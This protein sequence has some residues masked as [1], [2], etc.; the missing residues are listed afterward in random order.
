LFKRIE[1]YGL[2]AEKE[3]V[4]FV[5]VSSGGLGITLYKEGL[6]KYQQNIHI[7]TLRIKE[8]FDKQQR[9]S[10]YFQQALNEY[11]Y[12]VIEP[13]ESELKLHKIKYLVLSGT[14]TR[15][16]LSILGRQQSKSLSFVSLA[17]FY[18]L[19]E[20]VIKLNVPQI[21]KA[22]SLPEHTAEMVLPTVSL[23]KQI[24]ALTD[25]EQI[26]LP[27]DQFIDG[28]TTVHIAEKTKDKW[29]EKIELQIISLARMIGNKYQYDPKHATN[30]EKWSMALFDRLGKI[31]GMG[32][33][34]RLL[35]KVAAI[36]HD[37]GKFVSLR[38][39]YFY[40]YRLIVSS[41]ILGFSET[42]KALMANVAHYHSK[43]IPSDL[44]HNF[45]PLAKRQKV[46]VA[47]LA[48]IIRLADAI[49]RTHRQKVTECTIALKGD[50]LTITVSAK[51]DISLEEW[52]FLDKAP[53]FEDV[54]GIKP[55]LKR[56]A[57]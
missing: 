31:H 12:S 36:L 51:E 16:L 44:D 52:T 24:L 22:F 1:E 29:M 49:D 25:V 47:K 14:E 18:Q 55:I 45:A 27:C 42:E 23:Y 34:E 10:M 13:V 8:S 3:A 9:E 28:L 32:K 40:S 6:L 46:T 11:I 37:I 50:E 5:D 19:Y 41:D 4:L 48:A 35:L 30:V 53:F 20:Q 7:G 43:G 57:G 21:V 38:R 56:Q 54:F 2:A 33:R 26:V 17:D 15:L 39:H